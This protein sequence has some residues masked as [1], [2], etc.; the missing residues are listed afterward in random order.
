MLL[1]LDESKTWCKEWLSDPHEDFLG[2][3][4]QGKV[5]GQL[6]VSLCSS[7]AIHTYCSG[8][9]C[10]TGTLGSQI[11]AHGSGLSPPLHCWE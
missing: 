2:R 1:K 6:W 9:R 3:V 5:T 11:C 7:G 4:G 10:L 8:T